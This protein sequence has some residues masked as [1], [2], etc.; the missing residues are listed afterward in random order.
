MDLDLFSD[1]RRIESALS[2][3]SCTE[4]LAWCSENKASLRKV[5]V[6]YGNQALISIFIYCRIPLNSTSDCKSILNFVDQTNNMK[7]FYIS[8]SISYLGRRHTSFRFN[9]RV[10]CSRSRRGRLAAHTWLV[11]AAL[12]LACYNHTLMLIQSPSACTTLQDGLP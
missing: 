7:R 9:K 10:A 3:H 11:G 8:E 2:E 4:A 6:S 5:K 1:I 12:T